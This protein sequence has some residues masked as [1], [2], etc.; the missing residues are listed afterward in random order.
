[1][2]GLIVFGVLAVLAGVPGA[3]AGEVWAGLWSSRFEEVK[4]EWV[5]ELPEDSEEIEG[6]LRI[7][8]EQARLPVKARREGAWIEVTWTDAEG[9]STQARGVIGDGEWRGLTISG[10]GGRIVEYGR[11]ALRWMARSDSDGVAKH[12]RGSAAVRGDVL[13]NGIAPL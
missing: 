5:L 11:F 9:R 4:T 10:G 8:E 3:R 12:E 7:G 1:M 6:T 2:R 13:R